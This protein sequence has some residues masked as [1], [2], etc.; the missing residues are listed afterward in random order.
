MRRQCTCRMNDLKSDTTVGV[1]FSRATM[2]DVAMSDPVDARLDGVLSSISRGMTELVKLDSMGLTAT[3]L[4]KVLVVLAER[5][6]GANVMT[7]SLSDNSLDDEACRQLLTALKAPHFCPSL[8]AINLQGNPGISSEGVAALREAVAVRP[9][10]QIALDGAEVGAVD[11]VGLE[12]FKK[13]AV[14]DEEL[15]AHALPGAQWAALE[16]CLRSGASI[17]RTSQVMREICDAVDHEV[18]KEEAVDPAEVQAQGGVAVARQVQLP[19]GPYCNFAVGNG[20]LPLLWQLFTLE[21]APVQTAALRR[22]AVG[23]GSH[24]FHASALVCLLVRCACDP[25]HA[26]ADTE[27][28][29]A[30]VVQSS[31]VPRVAHLALSSPTCS[32]LHTAL[33][34]AFSIHT[35]PFMPA[36]LWEPLLQ[37]N[38]GLPPESIPG[39]PLEA[40]PQLLLMHATTALRTPIGD[41]S[42]IV[43]LVIQ[44][45]RDL[46]LACE[47]NAELRAALA[48]QQAWLDLKAEHGPLSKLL[49]QQQGSLA[50]G[51][52]NT[53]RLQGMMEDDIPASQ[54]HLRALF[55]VREY[56][57]MHQ[58]LNL[59]IALHQ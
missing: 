40:L 45:A 5:I 2:E 21:P 41:R 18:T 35:L 15:Q 14:L 23:V 49:A 52:P 54:M 58:S 24:R 7:I 28:L 27:A 16:E 39:E 4:G 59:G 34:D 57:Q 6:A 48:A 25:R 29:R 12:T 55:G 26:S 19:P 10:L 22:P 1:T 43:G 36:A 11:E 47:D 30:A 20:Q 44:L 56:S 8:L 31:L 37:P 53:A 38:F 51:K 17:S 42:G 9:E 13:G 33:L 50:G 32:C 46:Q 3:S